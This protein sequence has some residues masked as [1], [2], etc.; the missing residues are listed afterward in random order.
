MEVAAHRAKNRT[1]FSSNLLPAVRILISGAI[2][3]DLEV[4]LGVLTFEDALYLRS[5]SMVTLEQPYVPGL[6][7]TVP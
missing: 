6:G 3:P 5:A 1:V 7:L 2:D 4:Y